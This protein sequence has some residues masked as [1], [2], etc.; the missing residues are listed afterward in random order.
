MLPRYYEYSVWREE[1]AELESSLFAIERVPWRRAGSFT[2]PNRRAMEAPSRLRRLARDRRGATIL[3]F[4]LILP[5]FLVLTVGILEFAR[6]FNIWQV[7][8][9]SAR[10]GARIVA[11][12]PGSQSNTALVQAR[13]DDYLTSNGLDPAAATVTI[14]G[15]NGAPGTL[16]EVTVQ[17]PYTFTYFPG[18]ATLAGGGSSVSGPITLSSTSKMRNE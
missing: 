15:I 2:K 1:P 9:N 14:T 6:A 7:V 4:A 12:P 18:V 10:E 16:G 3:E 13:I 5:L 8:V 11:L 17:Y